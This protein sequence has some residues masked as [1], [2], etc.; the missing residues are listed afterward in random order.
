VIALDTEQL[1]TALCVMGEEAG[2]QVARDEVKKELKQVVAL[3]KKGKAD[4]AKKPSLQQLFEACLKGAERLGIAVPEGLLLMA[5]SLITIEG[6]ARGID[7]KVSMLRV[8]TPV[9]FRAAKPGLK[10]LVAMGKRLPQVAR[11]FLIR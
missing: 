1:V 2:R 7:P 5:K 8:A 9:L 10:D 11:Q 4:P 3:I 6:L